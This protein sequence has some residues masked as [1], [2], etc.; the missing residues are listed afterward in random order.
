MAELSIDNFWLKP[1]IRHIQPGFFGLNGCF[2]TLGRSTVLSQ[3][4]T[5]IRPSR[6]NVAGAEIGSLLS[7]LTDVNGPEPPLA[8]GSNAACSFR[9][10]VIHA[11]RSIFRE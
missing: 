1:V 2:R 3:R 8:D 6:R 7:P 4:M 11:P 5:G 9:F 10:A